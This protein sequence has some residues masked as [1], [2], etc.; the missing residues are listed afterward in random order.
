MPDGIT[1]LYTPYEPMYQPKLGCSEV[2][3]DHVSLVKFAWD[4]EYD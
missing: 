2:S 1:V 4:Y 3:V